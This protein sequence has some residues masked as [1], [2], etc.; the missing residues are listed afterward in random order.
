MAAPRRFGSGLSRLFESFGDGADKAND[1]A[2]SPFAGEPEI[3]MPDEPFEEPAFASEDGHG[4][5]PP[6]PPAVR[7]AGSL[8]PSEPDETFASPAVVETPRDYH[9]PDFEQDAKDLDAYEDA[10]RRYTRQQISSAETAIQTSFA[11]KREQLQREIKNGR[12]FDEER[13]TSAIYTTRQYANAYPRRVDKK[14]VNPPGFWENV[15]S[16]G[17]A[18]RLYRAAVL[19]TEALEQLRTAMRK[20]EEQLGALD[21]QMK[22]AI[23]LKEE[24]IKKAL[25]SDSGLSEFHERPE[26]KPLHKRVEKVKRER[27][28]YAKRLERGTVGDDEQ[29]DRAMGEQKL[30]FTELPVMGAIIGKVARFGQ[31][32]YFQL[33]DLERKESLL[34]YDP[35][36]DPLRN[37]VFDIYSVAGSVAAKLRRNDNGTAFRVA[38]HFKACW[39]NQDKA[40]ELYGQHRA[41]LRE[42][43]GLAPMT[44][45]NENEAEVIERLA[46][47]AAMVDGG[48]QPR[49]FPDAA[50]PPQNAQSL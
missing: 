32:S 12:S 4:V 39:R 50:Q 28:D 47:L 10:Q 30:S 44:P 9:I 13:R 40:E 36:L 31:H 11:Q 19:A 24:S 45:R 16:F 22:R 25:E 27:E 8:I 38:D 46:S 7:S 14:G 29:R 43:R 33:R 21:D 26:I 42:D 15:F 1:P 37:C 49:Q 35:R 20:R 18:G 6:V 17:R 34:S 48:G 2:G 3:L 23:Y 41:A 5:V